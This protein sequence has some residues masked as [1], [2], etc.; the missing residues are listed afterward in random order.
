[1]YQQSELEFEQKS[2]SFDSESSASGDDTVSGGFSGTPSSI[3][4]KVELAELFEIDKLASHRIYV[5]DIRPSLFEHCSW[6]ALCAGD[7]LDRRLLASRKWRTR[8]V[9][10]VTNTL[11][12]C[13]C[14]GSVKLL[15]TAIGIYLLISC[16]MAADYFLGTIYPAAQLESVRVYGTRVYG[17][18]VSQLEMSSFDLYKGCEDVSQVPDYGRAVTILGFSFNTNTS[19]DCSKER[20]YYRLQGSV[21]DG[22]TFQ[23]IGASEVRW[24]ATG[25]RFVDIGIA[26]CAGRVSYD[27][28]YPWPHH[29]GDESVLFLLTAG[30]SVMCAAVCALLHQQSAAKRTLVGASLAMAAM[31]AVSSAGFLSLHMLREAFYPG[32]CCPGYAL[33][34]LALAYRDRWLCESMLASGLFFL[35]ARAVNDCVVFEDCAYLA[36]NPPVVQ[37]ALAAAGA[38]FVWLRRVIV[39]EI[40]DGVAIDFT[41]F[42]HVWKQMVAMA[43]NRQPLARLQQ[44]TDAVSVRDAARPRQFNRVRASERTRQPSFDRACSDGSGARKTS[45]FRSA[46]RAE[47]EGATFEVPATLPATQGDPVRSVCQLYS[48]AL[49]VAP[50]LF[51]ACSHWAARSGGRLDRYQV[52]YTP[53]RL[54]PETL[55]RWMLAGV[56]KEPGRAIAKLLACYDGDV[57]CLLD[58]CRCRIVFDS[59]AGMARC[60]EVV[61]GPGPA[62]VVRVKN[63]LAAGHDAAESGGFR[64][65]VRGARFIFRVF[66]FYSPT[67]FLD[68]TP[69]R[70]ASC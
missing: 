59:V 36:S 61:A 50:L 46:F 44:L 70:F 63:G 48:Q 4:D 43:E 42:C 62:R 2:N 11:I 5:N 56:I 28:H 6:R 7:V 53:S 25:L 58:V 65:V 69:S 1:M 45:A 37:A 41:K 10:L 26:G 68:L 34:A 19:D 8:T 38:R 3:S 31:T 52:D 22:K 13:L 35:A 15:L 23:T 30:V 33:L 24:T 49:C 39:R 32:C 14:R 18:I 51:S 20:L 9:E 57:S 29:F 55:Q 64:A 21:D 47:P 16:F 60:L 66:A 27:Y 17:N 40:M 54:F 12:Y 67:L